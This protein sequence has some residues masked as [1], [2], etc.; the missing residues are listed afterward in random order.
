[1]HIFLTG[2]MGAGKSTLGRGTAQQ[3]NWPYLDLD[4]QI[5]AQEQRSIRAIFEK[6]GEAYFRRAEQAALSAVIKLPEA[7]LIST[8]GGTPCHGDNMQRL[9]QGGLTIYLR[10][11]PEVLIHRLQEMRAERPKL[12]EIPADQLAP[13]I[14][15]LLAE[16]EPFYR[17]AHL[18]LTGEQLS[19]AYLVSLAQRMEA[20]DDLR[21]DAAMKA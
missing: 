1:M 7:H 17:Q 5:E 10:P 9:K 12:R 21:G 15:H 20:G 3:L 8:G 16:R 13:F 4:D 14:H 2:F 6:E 19:V 18:T 11:A